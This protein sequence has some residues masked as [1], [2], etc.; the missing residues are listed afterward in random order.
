[1]LQIHSRDFFL[2]HVNCHIFILLPII[3]AQQIFAFVKR[4]L[5]F[6]L[7]FA[8]HVLVDGDTLLALRFQERTHAA[9]GETVF[10]DE[11]AVDSIKH[12]AVVNF[13]VGDVVLDEA[14]ARQAAGGI[15][16]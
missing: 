10:V 14:R 9:F 5:E 13:P 12:F 15:H 11:A 8:V 16:A 1:M 6:F 3:K 2:L 7:I 4:Q